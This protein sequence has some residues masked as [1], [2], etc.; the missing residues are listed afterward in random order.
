MM[1]SEGHFQIVFP[2][3]DIRVRDLCTKPYAG[4]PKGCP[5]YNKKET[6]PPRAP[7]LTDWLE[8][9][10]PIFAIWNRFP[11]FKH[12]L[13][14]KKK[15]P[16]WSE[17]QLHCCLY[18]QGT[19]RKQLQRIITQFKHANPHQIYAITTCPEAMGVNVT[20]TMKRIGIE[21]EWPPR[22]YAYQIALAGTLKERR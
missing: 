5:N 6:C 14:L 13:N 12:V 15:H 9:D 4:H 11:I 17:R 20:E 7:L 10:Y 1:E 8:F 16:N 2:V 18:W 22:R 19:A 3:M 21:L